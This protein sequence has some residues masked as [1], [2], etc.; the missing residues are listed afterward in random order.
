[1]ARLPHGTGKIIRV[2]VFANGQDVADALNAGADVVGAEDLV[3]RIQKGDMPFDTVIATPE[4]M[5]LVG[6]IGRI[7]GPRGMMP[8]PKMGS[9]TR[10]VAKAVKLAKAGAVQFRV[11]KAG[12]IQAGIGKLS[13]SNEQLL[14][15][16]RAFMVAVSDAK[17]EGMKGIYLY[18]YIYIYMYIPSPL[19]KCQI[20]IYMNT[21]TYI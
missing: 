7:L 2:C 13:F 20:C 17:P 21:H 1:V 11:E 9:V 8:T 19:Q 16:I 5:A 14:N 6:R 3:A 15:N 12:I 18:I 10:D 4:M